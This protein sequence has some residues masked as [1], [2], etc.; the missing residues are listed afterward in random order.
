[1]FIID[2]TEVFH[3]AFANGSGT[4]TFARAE[5]GSEL[6]QVVPVIAGLSGRPGVDSTFDMLGSG[7]MEGASTVTIGGTV[8]TDVFTNDSSSGSTLLD[9]DVFG[10]RN[11]TYRLIAPLAVE[12]P[13]MVTTAGGS[14]QLAGPTFAE[15]AFVD[16]TG[17]S[18]G[19][20]ATIGVPAD[21]AQASANT[22]QFI[23]L[24]GRGF[25]SQ[26]HGGAIYR[27]G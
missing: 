26:Q 2:G 3:E 7:F 27:T 9:G 14:F 13:I 25:I 8:I 12:G 10:T 17:V 1:M 4:Q 22:G 23:V 20:T 19:T 15:P 21:E 5:S 6:L 11:S 24:T 16:V 18:V